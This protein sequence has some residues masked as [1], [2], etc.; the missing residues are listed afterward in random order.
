MVYGFARQSNG[1]VTIYSEPGLGTSVRL[2]LP[3][4]VLDATA[5]TD[6]T[7]DSA[8]PTG[9]ETVLVVEDDRFVRNHVVAALESLGYRIA[10]ACDGREAL[11]MLQAGARPALLFT[12]V[13]MPGGVHGWELA[14][15]ARAM[16]PGL[17]VLFTSGYPPESLRVQL[18][19]DA[20][21][22][23]KPYRKAD[24]AKRVRD[25]IDDTM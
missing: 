7:D 23:A 2:Y 4:A 21:I 16:A 3:F 10:V 17:K 11:S 22:L 14:E 5:A 25:A 1:H 19:P 6:A 20:L 12:D 13:V 24:L 15:Q 18:A 9:T 8:P